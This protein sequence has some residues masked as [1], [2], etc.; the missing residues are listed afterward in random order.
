MGLE[1]AG[2]IRSVTPDIQ[3][4]DTFKKREVVVTTDEQYPQHILIEFAQD[5]CEYLDGYMPN[6]SVK[7]Q[8]N[9]KGRL[10]VNPQGEEKCFN[11]IQGWRIERLEVKGPAPQQDASASNQQF[12]QTTTTEDDD[13]SDLPF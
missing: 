12:N 11:Q 10:W 9:L 3:V 13:P 2:K 5:K 1:I 7:I 6:E 4:N 8:V